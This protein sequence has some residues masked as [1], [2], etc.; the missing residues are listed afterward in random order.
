[1]IMLLFL[2]TTTPTLLTVTVVGSVAIVVR[3]RVKADAELQHWSR[4]TLPQFQFCRRGDVQQLER[5]PRR[6]CAGADGQVWPRLQQ[7]P[8]AL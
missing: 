2:S 1:M 4:T 3:A 5:R 8:A 6:R 7:S